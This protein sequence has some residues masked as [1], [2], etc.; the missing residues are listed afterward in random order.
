MN[1]AG[2][3]PGARIDTGSGTGIIVGI[4]PSRG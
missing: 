3:A 1:V 2:L 4:G